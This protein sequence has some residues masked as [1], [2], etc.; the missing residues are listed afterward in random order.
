MTDHAKLE[1]QLEFP[2]HTPKV[3]RW[4]TSRDSEVVF[5]QALAGGWSCD[6]TFPPFKPILRCMDVD[7]AYN[8]F[9]AN[10]ELM[11]Q[12]A[13]EY[14]PTLLPLKHF[15]GR[16]RPKKILQPLHAP[17]VRKPRQGEITT[18]VDDAPT[19]LRQNIRQCRRIATVI[20]QMKCH[21]RTL[22]ESAKTAALETWQSVIDSPGFPG[23]FRKFSETQFG[24][25]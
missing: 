24:I 2:G 11:I 4:K 9:V 25:L 15:L 19:R 16:A 1:L 7:A 17:V 18:Q 3:Q 23:G 8:H 12:K 6:I 13:Y 22:S 5:Q 21:T 14:I 20:E 10:F